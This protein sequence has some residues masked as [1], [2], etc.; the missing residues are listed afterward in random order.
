[1]CIRDRGHYFDNASGTCRAPFATGSASA[2]HR[3]ADYPDR[4][5]RAADWLG[6]VEFSW[7]GALVRARRACRRCPV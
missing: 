7:R 4:P 6:S 1:M 3:L 2:G 5:Q